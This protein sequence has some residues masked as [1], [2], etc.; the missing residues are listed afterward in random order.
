MTL[1]DDFKY[2]IAVPGELITTMP[3]NWLLHPGYTGLF[4]HMCGVARLSTDSMNMYL[5]SFCAALL[6][7]G[8]MA[9][10]WVRIAEEEAMLAARFGERWGLHA[11]ERW[12]LLPGVW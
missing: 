4:L 2:R 3:Y 7:A 1:Q 9:S 6:M 5:G 11:A 10:L 8:F 12:H